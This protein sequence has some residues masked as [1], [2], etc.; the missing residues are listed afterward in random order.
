MSSQNTD[1]NVEINFYE[2]KTDSQEAVKALQICS[3]SEKSSNQKSNVSS[4]KGTGKK[5]A[6]ETIDFQ[7]V[8]SLTN[9]NDP[10]K[11]II[12]RVFLQVKMTRLIQICIYVKV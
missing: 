3:L 10:V 9:V 8:E 6:E 4:H 7:L 11:A 1:S 12:G 2:N 5:R